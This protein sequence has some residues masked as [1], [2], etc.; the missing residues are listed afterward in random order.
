M[1]HFY[2]TGTL[3]NGNGFSAGGF[4]SVSDTHTRGWHSG[5]EVECY[6]MTDENGNE[7]DRF[8]VYMTP[9]SS[10]PG[11]RVLVGQVTEMVNKRTKRRRPHWI[12]AKGRKSVT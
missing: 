1:A 9:G 3:G 7:F 10:G 2:T 12:P 8:D 6:A 11:H 4:R 5:V